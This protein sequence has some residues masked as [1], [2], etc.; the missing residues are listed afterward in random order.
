MLHKRLTGEILKVFY[1]VYNELGYGFLERVYQNTLFIELKQRGFDVAAQKKISVY[2]K[3]HLVGD[4][5]ADIIVNNKIILEL[6]AA[7]C[8]VE[9]FEYQLINYLKSTDCE[10]GLLLNFGK[11]P[12]FARKIFSNAKKKIHVNSPD[13]IHPHPIK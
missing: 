9:E 12:E 8:I 1:D 13:S 4:Y 3:E 11:E 5:F 6:K 10:V 7:K 2:Y